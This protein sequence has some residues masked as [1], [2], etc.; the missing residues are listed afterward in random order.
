MCLE[1][2]LRTNDPGILLIEPNNVVFHPEIRKP[3]FY[4]GS[5]QQLVLQSV[6][7]GC[8]QRPGNDDPIPGTEIKASSPMKYCPLLTPS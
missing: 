6:F 4:L 8:C 2:L 1:G 5:F 7:A 3:L